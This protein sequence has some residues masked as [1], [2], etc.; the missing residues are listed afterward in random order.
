MLAVALA[1]IKCCW[2]AK[3]LEKLSYEICSKHDFAV[4]SKI[5][6]LLIFIYQG[7]EKIEQ[8]S[9]FVFYPYFAFF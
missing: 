7:P 4:S 3:C 1:L 8:N 6:A 9:V 5:M 2:V